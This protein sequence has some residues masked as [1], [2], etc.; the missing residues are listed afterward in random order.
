MDAVTSTLSASATAESGQ[1]REGGW[2]DAS[3]A[4]R[5][6]SDA[7]WRLATLANFS[8]SHREE[9]TDGG[10]KPIPIFGILAALDTVGNGHINCV[11]LM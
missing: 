8:P 5:I 2:T 4:D 1:Q 10:R 6:G 9:D 7:L 3:W 11:L